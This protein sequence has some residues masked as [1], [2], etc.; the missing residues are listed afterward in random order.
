M[1]PD[2]G[3][4]N[5]LKLPDPWQHEAVTWLRRGTDVVLSAPTG[6]GKTYVFEL[7][8]QSGHFKGQAVYTVPTRALANDKFAEWQALRWDV[9]IATGDVSENVE[10]PVLV[11]TLETQLER[12]VRGEGPALLVIDEYQMVADAARGSHYEGAIALAPMETRLLLLSGSVGNPADVVAWLER[13][14]RRAAVVETQVRPVPLEEV[15]VEALP[16]GMVRRLE[17]WW[18]QFAGSVL[19]A[20][21]APLLIFAPRR[22]EAASIARKLAAELPPGDA[23]ELTAEQ[24]AVC[25]KELSSLLERRIAFHHSGLSYA[26]RAGVI[27]PLAKAGQLRVITATMGLAAGINFSV[28]SVHVAATSFHDGRSEHRLQPDELLQMF[29]RAGRRGLD[30]RGA[31]ITTRDGVSLA[32]GRPA[33]LHRCSV[34]AWPLFLRVMR[35]AA[36]SGGAPFEEAER[37]AERLYAKVPPPLGLEEGPD[38]GHVPAL[39]VESGKALFGLGGYE[40]QIFNTEGVWERR[41]GGKAQP[42]ALAEVWLAEEAVVRPAL[43]HGPFVARFARGIGRTCR[44]P[45][46]SAE[47][48]ERMRRGVEVPLGMALDEGAGTMFRPT[49]G[50]RRRLKLPRRLEGMTLADFEARWAGEVGRE[51]VAAVE[52]VALL[53]G[54]A[55]LVDFSEREG[56]LHAR[57]D[58]SELEVE[59]VEDSHGR[60]ILSP[61]ERVLRRDLG[62]E[63]QAGGERV[64]RQPRPGSPIHAWRQLGLIDELGVPTRRGEV[65]SFFQ[66]GEGLAVVAALEDGSYTVEDLAR[67][68][69]NLRAGTRF[70]LPEAAD[71]ERLGAV[72]RA[73]FGLVNH[74]GYLESGLPLDYGD[75]AAEVLDAMLH[76]GAPGA[77]ER[78]RGVAEGDLSRCYIE[79]V[80]LLRHVTH[81]PDHAWERWMGLKAEAARIL[82]HHSATL[83]HLFHLE[84][85]PL[86]NKQRTTR[87]RHSLLR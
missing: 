18:P 25:G 26:A 66:G 28:R 23:L 49:K 60:W 15:P 30:E 14:G 59:A 76:P 77:L 21:L 37:L 56:L 11:A 50:L 13:L 2:L 47:G 16:R 27:E 65:F 34:L 68:M 75:G 57:Y 17:G 33:R 87:T 55:R 31:V 5:S 70:D 38:P 82:S 35:H 80:S 74:H 46:V 20:D 3:Q 36:E 1:L 41:P 64:V 24:R 85:P 22:K 78:R 67:D 52:E 44:L 9:G 45:E 53:G 63:V 32:D 69:A 71:S 72:C 73:T 12:L 83:R 84:L 86:T 48:S 54:E 6:A 42:K 51:L 29:G 4:L 61:R 40:V 7:L 79:W 8:H 43:E 10:A 81:A 39:D 62:T 58:L 19:A